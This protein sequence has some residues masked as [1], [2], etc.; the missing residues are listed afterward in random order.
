MRGETTE[1]TDLAETQ[2]KEE[3]MSGQRLYTCDNGKREDRKYARQCDKEKEN[4][5]SG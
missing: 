3:E 5:L 4:N 1:K 2:Y